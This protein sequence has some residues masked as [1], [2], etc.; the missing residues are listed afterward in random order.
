MGDRVPAR[1]ASNTSILSRLEDKEV[2]GQI[3]LPG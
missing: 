1:K 2:D 3:S